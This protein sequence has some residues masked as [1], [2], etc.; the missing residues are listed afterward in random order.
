MP[1]PGT[2]DDAVQMVAHTLFQEST[3][4]SPV[5]ADGWRLGPPETLHLR[6]RT[7]VRE[8]RRLRT[9]GAVAVLGLGGGSRPGA[10]GGGRPGPAPGA[11]ALV[12]R[13]RRAHA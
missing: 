3:V 6:G 11:H 13:G 10:G 2:D 1:L 8:Q 7:G 9:A 4:D 12:G 5:A